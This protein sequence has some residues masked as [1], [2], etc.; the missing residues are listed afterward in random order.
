MS[1]I[2][3]LKNREQPVR[4]ENAVRLETVRMSMGM[5]EYNAG[6]PTVGVADHTHLHLMAEDGTQVALFKLTAVDGWEIVS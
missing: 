1:V 3:F 2:V 6:R 5:M 4:V